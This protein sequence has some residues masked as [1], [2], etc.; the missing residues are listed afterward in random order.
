MGLTLSD[1]YALGSG[2]DHLKISFAPRGESTDGP[3]AFM[4]RPTGAV[5]PDAPL[6]HHI[7]QDSGHISSTVFAGALRFSNTTL[8]LS[9]FNGTEPSPTAVDLPM[10]TPNSY[11]AR[12]IQQF[13]P[14]L[15][16][17][18][19]VADVQSPDPSQLSIGSI[20]RYSAS[21]YLDWNVGDGWSASDAIIWGLVNNFDQASALQSFAEEFW[22][23]K[24]VHNFWGRLEVLQ[25]TPAELQITNLG[26][27]NDGRWLTALTLGYT[28]DIAKWE[29]ADVGF[30]GS[31]TKDFLPSDFQAAYSGDSISARVFLQLSGQKM[32]DFF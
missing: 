1:T 24:D 17:M 30:G 4:H 18:I 32:W 22:V 16:A 6:G 8:E 2:T 10:G 28:Q 9:T 19:S 13:D 14:Q 20:S 23:H 26:S 27:P 7:G 15:Y 21:A 31:V 3:V 11:A 29:H 5:N 25:R 12:L